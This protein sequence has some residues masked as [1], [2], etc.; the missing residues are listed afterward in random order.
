[1]RLINVVTFELEE[2]FEPDI[3]EYAILSHT[4]AKEE[5]SFSIFNT[6]AASHKDGYRKIRFTCRQALI[7]GLQYA[8][9]DTCCIDKSSSS[10]LSEAINSMYN[11]YENSS[12]CYA[13]LSDVTISGFKDQFPKSRWFRRGWTLQELLAPG[14]VSFFDQDWNS[15]GS[16]SRLADEISKI[17]RIE[18]RALKDRFKRQTHSV[19]QRM[20][21]ASNRETTRVEDVAYSLLG[22]FGI[23]MP[24]L[25]G[26]GQKAFTRLQEGIVNTSPDESIF[27]WNFTAQEHESFEVSPEMRNHF[28]DGIPCDML[29]DSPDF[30]RDSGQ[31]TIGEPQL[32][33]PTFTNRGLK[34]RLPISILPDP[35]LANHSF[36]G[37]LSCQT[38]DK[39]KW[40]GIILK[41]FKHHPDLFY[42]VSCRQET[43][44]TTSFNARLAARA[45]MKTITIMK[46]IDDGYP[47]WGSQFSN[48]HY[49]T[50]QLVIDQKACFRDLD[51]CVSAIAGENQLSLQPFNWD[52]ISQILSIVTVFNIWNPWRLSFTSRHNLPEF[53]LIILNLRDNQE[54]IPSIILKDSSFSRQDFERI[55]NYGSG[56]S[57]KDLQALQDDVFVTY[58]GQEFRISLEVNV[59]HILNHHIYEI[60]MDLR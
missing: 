23:N 28:S 9:V 31:I 39:F 34:I 8:W 27:A 7:S 42:R 55:Q 60:S 15:I 1:M 18:K 37:F 12:F 14:S 13:Y 32:V 26:E 25:Y 4:W 6:P 53:S 11:W 51:Y 30:F 22:I 44:S 5:V 41:S 29:A 47:Y 10:E 33:E 35:Y 20:S 17:T 2:F 3:P 36:I 49:R 43:L 19:A 24:L 45:D 40:V 38:D 54:T 59:N 46:T 48:D 50:N 57:S 58:Q 16:K 21:W 52:P 56:W